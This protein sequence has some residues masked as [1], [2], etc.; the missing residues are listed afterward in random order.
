MLF[1]I[2]GFASGIISGM[3]IGGGAILIPAL[4]F[5]SPLSQHQAQGIN[6][7][8]FIP[9]AITALLV[10]HK[11]KSIEYKVTIPI[12]L[13]GIISAIIGSILA[14]NTSPDFLRRLFGI[15]LFA[16]GLLEFFKKQKKAD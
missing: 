11:N 8:V 9:A 1:F 7:I 10:H 15:F 4:V 12:I 2:I 5:F 3:G 16:I 13:S 6:L 14:L